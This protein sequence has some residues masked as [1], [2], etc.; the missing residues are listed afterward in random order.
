[1]EY[2]LH[3]ERLARR[4]ARANQIAIEEHQIAGLSVRTIDQTAIDWFQEHW[5]D[6]PG[7]RRTW[8]G[9]WNSP[10]SE[11]DFTIAI[12]LADTLCGLAAGQLTKRAVRL[13]FI[14]R[15]PGD[16]PL[17]GA[18]IPIVLTVMDNYAHLTD[19]E[20]LRLND[21]AT[22]LIPKYERFGFKLVSGRQGVHVMQR[23]RT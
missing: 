12:W 20:E 8:D 21:V 16:N 17:K 9:D 7:R 6:R 15:L 5:R 2:G 22:G 14:E 11:D 19:R 10:R 13:E 4:L 18:V 3:L 23:K 1:M